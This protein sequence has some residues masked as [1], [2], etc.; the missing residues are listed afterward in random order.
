MLPI[1]APSVKYAHLF[2]NYWAIAVCKMLTVCPPS[3]Q[4]TT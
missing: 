3:S 4:L 1:C 2:H